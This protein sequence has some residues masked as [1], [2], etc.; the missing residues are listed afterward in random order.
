MGVLKNIIKLS[1]KSADPLKKLSEFAQK[2]SP[3]AAY[4]CI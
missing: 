1:L 4:I 3:K 2:V